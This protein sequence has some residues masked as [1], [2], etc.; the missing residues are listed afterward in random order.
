MVAT[1]LLFISTVVPLLLMISA[2]RQREWTMAAFM[3]AVLAIALGVDYASHA[4]Q[5]GICLF[6]TPAGWRGGAMIEYRLY[7]FDPMTGLA[8]TA[9]VQAEDDSEARERAA[10]QAKGAN[11]ELWLGQCLIDTR[12]EEG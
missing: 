2:L 3:A 1:V 4:C 5:D 12:W 10:A 11:Y 7:L 6:E 9:A 8:S